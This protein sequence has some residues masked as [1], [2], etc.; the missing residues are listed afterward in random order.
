MID[1]YR[2]AAGAPGPAKRWTFEELIRRGGYYDSP[3]V[4]DRWTDRVT[5]S[6]PERD[7]P[8]H[9]AEQRHEFVEGPRLVTCLDPVTWL[10]QPP[11]R[12][13]TLVELLWYGIQN[14]YALAGLGCDRIYALGSVA[15]RHWAINGRWTMHVPY[16]SECA[17][18]VRLCEIDEIGPRDEP[19][20][21]T[22]RLCAR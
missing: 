1:A 17:G 5:V 9:L 2:V 15:W 8:K 6:D 13:A 22:T 18:H 7:G 16:L 10:C 4:A 20:G 14:P 12:R 3:L 19:R 21:R 11:V